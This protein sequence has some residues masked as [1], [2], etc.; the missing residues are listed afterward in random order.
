MFQFQ[1]QYGLLLALLTLNAA[2]STFNILRHSVLKF[3][4]L[5]YYTIPQKRF[6]EF[7]NANNKNRLN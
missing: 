2:K 6:D 4:I 7:L 3:D 1:M 5:K